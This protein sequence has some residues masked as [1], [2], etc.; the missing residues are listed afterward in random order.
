VKTSALAFACYEKACAPPP[1]GK[2]G[3][4]PGRG[5]GSPHTPALVKTLLKRAENQEAR[6]DRLH[7][8]LSGITKPK[9]SQ[10]GTTNRPHAGG[11]GGGSA[12]KK[13]ATVQHSSTATHAAFRDADAITPRKAGGAVHTK[14]SG[15]SWEVSVT[16]AQGRR[17]SHVKGRAKTSEEALEKIVREYRKHA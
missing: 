5:G 3:S 13:A 16:D 8:H 10:D 12:G 2:G 9:L 14:H 17:V 11:L 1:A 7:D 6:Q 4:L 15:K